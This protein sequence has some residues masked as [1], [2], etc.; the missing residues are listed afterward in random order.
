MTKISIKIRKRIRRIAIVTT[1]DLAE[2]P[3][4]P[5]NRQPCQYTHVSVHGRWTIS[6]LL[7]SHDCIRPGVWVHDHISN[8][9]KGPRP[10]PSSLPSLHSSLH[11]PQPQRKLFAREWGGS[12]LLPCKCSDCHCTLI[13]LRGSDHREITLEYS[14]NIKIFLATLFYDCRCK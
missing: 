13:W 9:K 7:S 8:R 11:L 10:I 3:E 2:M 6:N 14:S 1:I 4:D 12:T 5:D